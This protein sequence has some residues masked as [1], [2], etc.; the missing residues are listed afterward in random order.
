MLGKQKKLIAALKKGHYVETACALAGIGIS[1]YYRWLERGE[2]ELN[3][4]QEE[5]NRGVE[6]PE[7]NDN[8]SVFVEF[9]EAVTYAN[10]EAEDKALGVIQDAFGEKDWRAAINFLERRFFTRW[11]KR[12]STELSGPNGG[13]IPTVNANVDMTDDMDAQKAA[14]LYQNMLKN[15]NGL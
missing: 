4:V 14:E 8:E 5:L 13:P 10:A 15:V 9:W 1:T 3:R 12:S 6:N 7:F 2:L 11:R